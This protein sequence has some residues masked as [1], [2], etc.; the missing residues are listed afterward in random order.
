MRGKALLSPGSC[1]CSPRCG[2]KV[3]QTTWL[4]TMKLLVKS[5]NLKHHLPSSQCTSVNNY[6]NPLLQCHVLFSVKQ[7]KHVG[8]L[9]KVKTWKKETKNQG[10]LPIVKMPK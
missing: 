6:T 7:C 5:M 3:V 4:E 1:T 8:N 2:R 10:V 9:V